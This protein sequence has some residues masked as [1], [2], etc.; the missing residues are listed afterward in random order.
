MPRGIVDANALRFL[1]HD[2]GTLVHFQITDLG[3]LQAKNQ[4]IDQQLV[5]SENPVSI[6]FVMGAHQC[7]VR[8]VWRGKRCRRSGSPQAF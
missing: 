5:E 6:G 2:A 3:A 7:L 4:G 1:S 8:W